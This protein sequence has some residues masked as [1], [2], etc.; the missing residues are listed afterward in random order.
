MVVY[1]LGTKIIKNNPEAKVIQIE[2]WF[3]PKKMCSSCKFFHSQP[4]SI[5]P[6]RDSETG[7]CNH[8]GDT[9]YRFDSCKYWMN[10]NTNERHDR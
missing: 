2:K 3:T 10:R 6:Y 7:L 1:R 8:Y 5:E 9:V 4:A